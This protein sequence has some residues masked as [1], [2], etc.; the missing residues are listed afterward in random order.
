MDK[1]EWVL[2]L[3]DFWRLCLFFKN[4]MDTWTQKSN[5]RSAVNKKAKIELS[6]MAEL[7]VSHVV[8]ALSIL[9]WPV[10]SPS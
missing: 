5:Q 8:S 9:R 2:W 1:H 7:A 6:P 4:Y 10:L 3:G